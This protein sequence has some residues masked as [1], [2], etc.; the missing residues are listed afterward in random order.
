MAAR[1]HRFVL[2]QFQHRIGQRE[3][4]LIGRRIFGIGGQEVIEHHQRLLNQI[5]AGDFLL[6]Q[7]GIGGRLRGFGVDALG[8]RE[9][10]RG[11]VRFRRILGQQAIHH[12]DA[13]QEFPL[14]FQ[15]TG[16]AVFAQE[17]AFHRGAEH[18]IAPFVLADFV[19]RRPH[20][21]DL[22]ERHFQIGPFL[23]DDFEVPHHL[24]RR[25]GFQA[26]IQQH[27]GRFFVRVG[28]H[29]PFRQQFVEMLA[30]G[31]EFLLGEFALAQLVQFHRRQAIFI[32]AFAPQ[33]QHRQFF[34]GANRQ[35]FGPI[36]IAN[37][38]RPGAV[39]AGQI[40]VEVETNFLNRPAVADVERDRAGT[41]FEPLE[42]AG[43]AAFDHR[44]PAGQRLGDDEV[45]Q[46]IVGR[47]ARQIV[48][49][50][51]QM[52]AA[53]LADRQLRERIAERCE[54]ALQVVEAA[55]NF[56]AV[57]FQ[58]RRF[59]VAR[60]SPIVGGVLQFVGG[61][62]TAQDRLERVPSAAGQLE[63]DALSAGFQ[64]FPRHVDG[65]RAG[66]GLDIEHLG[67]VVVD[68]HRQLV[69]LAIEPRAGKPMGDGG[70]GGAG[71]FF[72]RPAV[73]G[74]VRHQ[75]IHDLFRLRRLRRQL[76]QRQ[77]VKRPKFDRRLAPRQRT[78]GG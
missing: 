11:D 67:F 33:R 4:R 51:L 78:A 20:F 65:E 22:L 61:D 1:D 73:A 76:L 74:A 62:E 13:A 42:S 18:Q 27:A 14:R 17:A 40:A 15:E 45:F 64:E 68:E 75:P 25:P 39:V 59:V 3:R 55:R 37:H 41:D 46:L 31:F 44:R 35:T 71:R 38:R 48:P 72:R 57:E 56:L 8:Q 16:H 53:A 58:R 52:H 21:H 32:A 9:R 30:G 36:G 24:R 2:L 34:H 19:I 29:V 69:M 50:D 47:V 7:L 49:H 12:L 77:T 70:G 5:D 63:V 28:V 66:V 26:D 10:G 60:D 43:D 6:A 23:L 54:T